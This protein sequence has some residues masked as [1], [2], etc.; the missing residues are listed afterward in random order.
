MRGRSDSKVCFVF[1]LS[2]VGNFQKRAQ[3]QNLVSKYRAYAKRQWQSQNTNEQTK[4]T[5]KNIQKQRLILAISTNHYERVEQSYWYCEQLQ[6]IAQ[7]STKT[8]RDKPL[9]H[10]RRPRAWNHSSRRFS[11][12]DF[13]RQQAVS[14]FL[15]KN[16]SIHRL[17]GRRETARPY[18]TERQWVRG[19]SE[20]GFVDFVNTLVRSRRRMEKANISLRRAFLS[21]FELG[22]DPSCSLQRRKSLTFGNLK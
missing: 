11:R 5:K 15:Y 14:R 19:W 21:I 20:Y 1:L 9:Q 7:V 10:P 13:K 8:G 22:G 2:L 16:A 4:Q 3:I 17:K 12:S 6:T 18:L